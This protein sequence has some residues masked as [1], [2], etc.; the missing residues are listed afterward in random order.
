MRRY[1]E[2]LYLMHYHD[3]RSEQYGCSGPSGCRVKFV[4]AACGQAAVYGASG[5]RRLVLFGL[6]GCVCWE[7]AAMQQCFCM[8]CHIPPVKHACVCLGGACVYVRVHV[9]VCVCARAGV[10]HEQSSATRTACAWRLGP[11]AWASRAMLG[12]CRP[13]CCHSS[14][15]LGCLPLASPPPVGL[16]PAAQ[17]HLLAYFFGLSYYVA[18]PLTLV[19]RDLFDFGALISAFKPVRG[20][21][22]RSGTARASS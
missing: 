19:P 5:L 3:S 20:G 4:G 7:F 17:M 11:A 9:R 22:S 15:M 18:V 14:V 21:R 1:L 2:T 13:C 10:R 12:G 6:R 8:P 16:P